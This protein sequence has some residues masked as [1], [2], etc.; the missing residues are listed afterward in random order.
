MVAGSRG[1]KGGK[2]GEPWYRASGIFLGNLVI[3]ALLLPEF[4]DVQCPLKI[5]R[6]DSAERIFSLARIQGPGLDLEALSLAKRIG[7]KIKQIPAASKV[8]PG[9]RIKADSYPAVFWDALKVRFW[10]WTNNYIDAPPR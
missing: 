7:Y 9:Y 5:F 6:A 4:W 1:M 2:Y 8:E 10:L 3:Q